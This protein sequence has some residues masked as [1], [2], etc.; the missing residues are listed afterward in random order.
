MPIDEGPLECLVDLPAARAEATVPFGLD[1]TREFRNRGGRSLDIGV[2]VESTAVAPGMAGE[3][4]HWHQFQHVLEPRAC[5]A[6][7]TVE[8]PTHR[9]HRGSAVDTDVCPR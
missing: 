1:R 8:H 3:D 7:Q 2:Q 4:V 6:Q 9:E 5:I